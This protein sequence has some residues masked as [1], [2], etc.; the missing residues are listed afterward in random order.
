MATSILNNKVPDRWQPN[1]KPLASYV[2][3]VCACSEWF[4]NW[5]R[6][7]QAPTT[8]WLGAFFHTR[9]FLAGVKLK[10]ARAHHMDVGDITFDFEVMKD[11]EWVSSRANDRE[12]ID[13]LS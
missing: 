5:W 3:D 7:G 9:A 10:H 1:G 12:S 4:S 2:N 13:F 11:L 6:V 8:Y